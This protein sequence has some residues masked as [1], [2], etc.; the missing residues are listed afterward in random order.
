MRLHPRQPIQ[1]TSGS[2]CALP[3]TNDPEKHELAHQTCLIASVL[4]GGAMGYR[5]GSNPYVSAPQLA[6]STALHAVP[7]T[8]RSPAGSP[9]PQPDWCTPL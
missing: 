4:F 2:P 7:P 3:Q 9:A 6:R 8:A 5:A 1:P